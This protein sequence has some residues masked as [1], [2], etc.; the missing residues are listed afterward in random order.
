MKLKLK[1]AVLILLYW[2][3]GMGLGGLGGIVL[4]YILPDQE[5]HGPAFCFGML[6]GGMGMF[7][8]IMRSMTLYFAASRVAARRSVTPG[9]FSKV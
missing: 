9:L 1:L 7:I 5:V 6:T 8:G 4:S 3:A 2:T